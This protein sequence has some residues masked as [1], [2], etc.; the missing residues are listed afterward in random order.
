MVTLFDEADYCEV[1]RAMVTLL[2]EGNIK[3][4]STATKL[5]NLDDFK[6][7]KV[8]HDSTKL[9][10]ELATKLYFLPNNEPKKDG[11][12]F[13]FHKSK[14]GESKTISCKKVIYQ[15]PNTRYIINH[16]DSLVKQLK[17]YLDEKENLY[18]YD[19]VPQFSLRVTHELFWKVKDVSCIYNLHENGNTVY[20][21]ETVDLK[22]TIRRHQEDNKTFDEVHYSLLPNHQAL[23][24]H[25]EGFFLNKYKKENGHLPKYNKQVPYEQDLKKLELVVSPSRKDVVN[26]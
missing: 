16:T 11:V 10:P 1:D 18:C 6:C 15:N 12:N 19:I 14:K 21:G 23:R 22:S 17:I 25:W 24:K 26:A 20:Y 13:L 9:S 5:M 8:G 3:F 2:G 4:N 7:M